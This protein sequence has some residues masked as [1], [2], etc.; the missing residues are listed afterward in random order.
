MITVPTEGKTVNI[1]SEYLLY[2]ITLEINVILIRV[3]FTN[4]SSWA[5][6]GSHKARSSPSI[7]GIAPLTLVSLYQTLPYIIFVWISEIYIRTYEL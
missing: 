3:F 5:T 2:F 7:P 4:S 1:W 6:S